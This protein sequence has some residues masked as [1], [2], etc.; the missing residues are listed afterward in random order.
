MTDLMTIGEFAAATW[1]S[2]KALRLYDRNGLL[3]P[4]SVD[5]FNGYRKYSLA[6]IEVARMITMLRRIDM[7][8]EQISELLN[9]PPGARSAHVARYRELEAEKHAR[10]ESLAQFLEH[11]VAEGSLDGEGQPGSSRFEVSLRTVPDSALLTSTQ[12]TSAREL[13]EVIQSSATRLFE[14]AGERGGASG[15]PVVIYHGQVG[16][17]SDGPIEVCVPLRKRRRAHRVEP[18]HVQ[19]FTRVLSKDVQFPRILAAF[20]AVRARANQ[21]GFVPAGP[22]REIYRP[23]NPESVPRCEVALPIIS[24]ESQPTI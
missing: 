24:H 9:L 13:P 16:W 23:D 18:E 22:P 15:G 3:S 20:E 1:L 5:P 14:L 8:L 17:E 10:R 21:L 6:Q 2:P 11:A 12:H 7:P 4:D 19:L